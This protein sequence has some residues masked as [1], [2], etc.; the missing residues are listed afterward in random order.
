MFEKAYS[1]AKE[2]TAP[3]VISHRNHKKECKAGIGSCVIINEEGWFVSAFH[4]FSQYNQMLQSFNSYKKLQQDRQAVEANTALKSHEKTRQLNGS[5]RIHAEAISNVS[6]W[7]GNDAWS[8]EFVHAVPPVDLAIGKLI[9]F[10]KS[11]VR[12]YPVF[13]DSTKRMDPGK[14]LCK[15]GFPFHSIEPTFDEATNV[16][17]LPPGAIPIL[18]FQLKESSRVQC[19]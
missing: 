3:I 8:L 13:K 7:F 1:I 19:S 16:F 6:I 4:I 9:N 14:S 18:F 17:N 15:L 5:L 2:F 10:D 12:V 11:Q